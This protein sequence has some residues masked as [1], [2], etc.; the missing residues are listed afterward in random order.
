MS[1][2]EELREMVRTLQASVTA[3]SNQLVTHVDAPTSSGARLSSVPDA[4]APGTIV[5][6][7]SGPLVSAQPL[8][9][10]FVGRGVNQEESSVIMVSSSASSINNSLEGASLYSDADEGENDEDQS[11]SVGPTVPPALAQ[12]ATRS[13]TRGRG[14]SRPTTVPEAVPATTPIRSAGGGSRGARGAGGA[15]GGGFARGRGRGTITIP[16]SAQT[17]PGTFATPVAPPQFP[18]GSS[19]PVGQ[20]REHGARREVP[21]QACIRSAAWN[22]STGECFDSLQSTTRCHRCSSGHVCAPLPEALVLPAT[23][24]V[25]ARIE[26]AQNVCSL[27][28]GLLACS[29]I[30]C[31]GE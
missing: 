22:R 29:L 20:G 18:I 11:V 25:I 15:R 10:L 28:P 7:G 24:L 2:H 4:P 26:S 14:S 27:D 21:C 23:H 3:L 17:A 6:S 19:A 5:P 13:Q 12:R 16:G 9:D 1:T 31:S 30:L 8:E